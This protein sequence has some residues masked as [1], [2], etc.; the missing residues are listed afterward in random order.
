MNDIFMRIWDNLMERTQGPM[1][2]RFFL[3]PTVAIIFAIR[4]ALRD[5]KNKQVPYLWRLTTSGG[6]RREIVK[7]GWKDFGKV[8]I[9][10][11]ILDVTYQL[12]VIFSAKTET[13]FYILE[14]IIV[15]FLLSFIPYIFFRGPV[16]RLVRM[17]VNRKKPDDN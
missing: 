16:N 12:V 2:L 8:F 6:N 15:A 1:N 10:A 5:V 11:V 3:Q 14:S 13:R 7:E 17:W 9:I 4:A